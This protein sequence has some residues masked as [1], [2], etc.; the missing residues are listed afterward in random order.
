MEK[1]NKM[2]THEKLR[3]MELA[4]HTVKRDTTGNVNVDELVANYNKL[5]DA[6]KS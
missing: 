6:C 1:L 2:E 5:L 4:S 3:L